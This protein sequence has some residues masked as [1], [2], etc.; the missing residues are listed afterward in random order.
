M[1]TA[2]G[3]VFKG[4]TIY[5]GDDKD[6]AMNQDAVFIKCTG[7]GTNNR[8]PK[9]RLKEHPKCGKCG[10][11]I[12][13]ETTIIPCAGCGTKNRIFKAL[14]DDDPRCGKCHEP[15]KTIP[16]YNYVVE[17]TD[18]TFN[19]EVLTFPGTVLL[20]FYS[21]SCPH[22]HTL[23]PILNQ[24]A[25]D[26]AGQAKITKLNIERSPMTASRYDVMS[27]PT[28]IFFKEGKEVNKLLGAVSREE[29]ESRIKYI[30]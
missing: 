2:L 27:T 22:C 15:L 19:E 10:G 6:K 17:T 1:M 21:N 7:C 12:E 29:I 14:L 13:P 16:F 3:L 25:S 28:I 18:R 4:K 26:Y 30:L 9:T 11:T 8:I 20:E 24:M 23:T 5:E